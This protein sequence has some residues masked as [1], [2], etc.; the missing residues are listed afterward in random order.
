MANQRT[1][2]WIIYLFRFIKDTGIIPLSFF[3]RTSEFDTN[4]RHKQRTFDILNRNRNLVLVVLML[5][6]IHRV[7]RKIYRHQQIELFFG[8]RYRHAP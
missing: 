5:N 6:F 8:A 7:I 1:I 3:S 4:T 2:K